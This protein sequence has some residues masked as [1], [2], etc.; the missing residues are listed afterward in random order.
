MYEVGG[1]TVPKRTSWAFARTATEELLVEYPVSRSLTVYMDAH[2]W[3]SP[4][5]PYRVELSAPKGFQM[6]VFER[7]GDR[8]AAMASEPVSDHKQ[9]VEFSHP[10]ASFCHQGFVW[11]F[12]RKKSRSDTKVGKRD[13]DSGQI[14]YHTHIERMEGSSIQQAGSHSTQV[15]LTTYV[16]RD[17]DDLRRVLDF[18]VE[19]F[20]Q[21]QL[22]PLAAKDANVQIQTLNAQLAYKPNPVIIKEAGKTLRNL[23][24]G[25]VAGLITSA[26][27]P[28][29]WQ[30]VQ[31][32]LVRL[33]V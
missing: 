32:V 13:P 28:S 5:L 10:H 30:T 21:L 11:S 29:V 27:Q 17:F 24:E 25:V 31:E 18:L 33:F 8:I 19:N 22:D 1:V 20:E 15:Q 16:Q 12:E 7:L 4:V 14:V 6:F 3:L 23:T 9:T 26:V 2:A